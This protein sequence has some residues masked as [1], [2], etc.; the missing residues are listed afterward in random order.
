MTLDETDHQHVRAIDAGDVE[1]RFHGGVVRTIET[2]QQV[3]QVQ[4]PPRGYLRVG[5]EGVK[6][7]TE[8]TGSQGEY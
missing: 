4:A 6:M 2:E 1:E 3:D 5:G 7:N 8:G